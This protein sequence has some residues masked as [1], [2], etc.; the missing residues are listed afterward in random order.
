[1][2]IGDCCTI[3]KTDWELTLENEKEEVYTS[4]DEEAYRCT[5]TNLDTAARWQAENSIVKKHVK[6]PPRATD[7]PEDHKSLYTTSMS[8]HRS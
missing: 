6:R 3:L 7:H 4:H 5:F 1:M 2:P 8:A